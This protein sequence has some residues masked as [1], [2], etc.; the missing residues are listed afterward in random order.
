[1][2]DLVQYFLDHKN[3]FHLLVCYEVPAGPPDIGVERGRDAAAAT[4]AATF[5]G[6]QPPTPPSTPTH[7]RRVSLVAEDEDTFARDLLKDRMLYLNKQSSVGGSSSA[8]STGTSTPSEDWASQ[9]VEMPAPIAAYALPPRVLAPTRGEAPRAMAPDIVASHLAAIQE[10]SWEASVVEAPGVG[11]PDGVEPE[12]EVNDLMAPH[13]E[14]LDILDA[15]EPDVVAMNSMAHA[16]MKP[17]IVASHTIPAERPIETPVIL[18]EPNEDLDLMAE[19]EEEEEEEMSAELMAPIVG[20]PNLVVPVLDEEASYELVAVVA[21]ALD[22]ESAEMEDLPEDLPM[23]REESPWTPSSPRSPSSSGERADESVG[24]TSSFEDSKTRSASPTHPLEER[25]DFRR[26]PASLE[27]Q[28]LL[29]LLLLLLLSSSLWL[30]LLLLLL[31]REF[32]MLMVVVVVVVDF[33][34]VLYACCC[35]C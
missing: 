23:D 15:V 19:E 3:Y 1:M 11:A 13:M 18:V 10:A 22:A 16:A 33:E 29:S 6:D 5:T 28:V 4:S 30:L 7:T 26:D 9:T 17:D 24:V 14:A 27:K 34:R 2:E 31:L 32:F 25:V 20:E 35:C 21:A 12:R 8:S